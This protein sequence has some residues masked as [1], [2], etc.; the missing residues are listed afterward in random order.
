MIKKPFFNNNSH[1]SCTIYKFAFERNSVVTGWNPTQANFLELLQRIYQCEY[2][3]YQLIL[4]HSCDYLQKT[5]IK[6]KVATDEGKQPKWN[7]TLN[8]YTEKYIQRTNKTNTSKQI[9]VLCLHIHQANNMWDIEYTFPL[10]YRYY[11]LLRNYC[12]IL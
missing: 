4:L 7:V 1:T 8:I 5:S 11:K 10:I 6:I 2:H 12:V 3:M 9:L